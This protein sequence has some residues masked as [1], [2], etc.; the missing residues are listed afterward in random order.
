MFMADENVDA[1]I[2]V[3]LRADGHDVVW[4]A[5][6]APGIDDEQVMALANDQ[7]RVL[8]TTDKDFGDLVFRLGRVTAGVILLRLEGLAS[9]A[10]AETVSLAVAAHFA[11]IGGAFSVIAPGVMRIR[12]R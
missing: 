5:E 11:E 9:T 12:T 1:G 3:R 2:V 7:G 6:L 8:I 10:K 4:V